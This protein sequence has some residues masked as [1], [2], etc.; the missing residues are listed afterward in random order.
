MAKTLCAAGPEK[1]A[2]DSA[3]SG[4]QYADNL[5]TWAHF[6]KNIVILKS[7]TSVA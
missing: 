7:H 1:D 5:D 6:L 4:Q 2:S 3:Y